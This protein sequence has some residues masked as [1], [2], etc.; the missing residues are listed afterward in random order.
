MARAARCQ[1]AVQLFLVHR[2]GDA[3][4]QCALSLSKGKNCTLRPA[5]RA[6]QPAGLPG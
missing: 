1:I 6:Y 4:T 5:Q 2:P 3:T